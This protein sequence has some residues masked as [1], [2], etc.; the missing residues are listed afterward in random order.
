MKL[1]VMLRE[2][3]DGKAGKMMFEGATRYEWTL[4]GSR[5]TINQPGKRTFQ[6]PSSNVIFMI[7]EE[8][9]GKG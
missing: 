1:T 2:S 4:E 7:K 6:T 9:D 5:F 8:N 3:E